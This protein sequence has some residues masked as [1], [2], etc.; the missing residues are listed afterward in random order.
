MKIYT[1][2]GDT[3]QTSLASGQRVSKSDARLE[4]Y[5]TAD[6][7]NAFVGLLRS[8]LTEQDD[9]QWLAW[10]QHKLF[11]LG[12]ALA[13]AKGDWIEESDVQQLEQWIDA[14]QADLPPLRGFVLPGGNE[15][16]SYCHVCRTVTRRLERNLVGLTVDENGA[17]LRFVNRLS[18]FWFVFA[19]KTAKKAG[20]ELFFWKK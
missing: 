5:G 11:N 8:G 6:E 4:A 1:K 15:Q 13:E 9:D 7:L 14:M 17:L 20:I 2:T 3:G 10:I 19:Q 12:A 16:V 18:D